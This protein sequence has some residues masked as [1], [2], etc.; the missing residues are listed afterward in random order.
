MSAK[1]APNDRLQLLIA[2]AGVSYEALAR[3]LCHIAA[4]NGDHTLRANKSAVAHW[5]AG[6]RPQPRTAGYL[7]EALSR[8]LAR[9]LTP[10][11]LGLRSG[12]E[13]IYDPAA[14]PG[15]PVAA[16]ARLGRADVDRRTLISGAAYSVAALVLPLQQPEIAARAHAAR[17]RPTVAVGQGEIDAVRQMTVAFNAAD[18]RLGGGHARSAVVE[19]LTTDV[20][21]FLGGSFATEAL[22]KSMFGA[23]AQ[24]AYLAGWKA[25]DLGYS[26]LAQRYYLHSY[27]LASEADPH[28][29]AAYGLRILAHQAMDLG[30]REHCVDLADAALDRVKGRVDPD[31]ESL[32]WLTAARAHAADGSSQEA[33]SALSTAERLLDRSL[34]DAAPEWAS[35]GGPAEARLAN[36]SGK[37]LQAMG[38]LKAAEE[39]LRRSA[40]CWNAAT[41]PRIHALTL[42]D[43]AETQCAQG[44]VEAACQ[45]WNS[46]LDGMTGI[47]SARTRDAITIMR[48]NLAVYRR[49]GL[50][51]AQRLETRAA[52]LGGREPQS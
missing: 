26:G 16:V 32:F 1:T 11:D 27:Q 5:V 20:T 15:D 37:A 43:L 17:A 35:L 47:R 14:L 3:S 7:A 44:N 21:A 42:A 39:Q 34:G 31:T 19:Y 50:T 40:R 51:A 12:D 6:T 41:H 45:T 33:R 25:H 28:A 49:R 36:Q 38:D 46:A 30:L 9:P 24:L 29:H 52:N 13:P 48:A 2:Q 18:E 10:A 23:A 4:E 8:R 22:R